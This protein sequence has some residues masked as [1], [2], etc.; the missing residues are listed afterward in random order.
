V[1]RKQWPLTFCSYEQVCV[2]PCQ[3]T[4]NPVRK[5]AYRCG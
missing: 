3:V 2:A 1:C 5:L 4:E